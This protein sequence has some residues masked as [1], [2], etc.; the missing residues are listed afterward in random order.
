MKK[1]SNNFYIV[2]RAGGAGTRL[3]PLSTEKCPKQFCDLIDQKSMLENTLDRVKDLVPKENI[4]ISTS[5]KFKKLI[6][7]LLPNFPKQNLILEPARRD[8]AAAVALESAIIY[9][10]NP[11]ATIASLGSDHL[12]K[13]VGE[14]K[15][16]LK[17]ASKFI[18]THPK[19][20]L[21]IGIKPTAPSTGFGYIQKSEKICDIDKADIYNVRRFTEK[22]NEKEAIKIFNSKKYLVN[23]NLFVWRAKTILSLFKTH[24]PKIFSQISEISKYINKKHFFTNLAKIYPQIEKTAID[25]AILEKCKEIAVIEA[26]MGWSDIGDWQTLK[27]ELCKDKQKNLF[28]GKVVE[29]N[30]KNNLLYENN[31]KKILTTIDLEGIGVIDTKDALLVCNLNKSQ[32]VKKLIEKLR[33]NESLKK[34]L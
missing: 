25:Y 17:I 5:I 3:W 1:V 7:D 8:T 19:Y 31:T 10:K 6:G 20:L 14:F 23:G 2:I 32:D 13:R 29:L 9:A 28:K 26:D 22:P 24:Q 27:N 12:I 4:Y 30:S 11:E 33:N 15:R 18:T 34:Y 16:V 21:L